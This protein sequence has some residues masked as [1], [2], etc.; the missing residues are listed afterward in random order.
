MK[1]N[2]FI[3]NFNSD[4]R[5]LMRKR[6]IGM[7]L[8]TDMADHMSHTNVLASKVEAKGI[9]REKNNGFHLIDNSTEQEKFSSQ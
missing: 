3:E 5:N 9:T 4:E 6:M 8:A 2:C 7:I 1:D